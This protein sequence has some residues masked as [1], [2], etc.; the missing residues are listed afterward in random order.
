MFDDWGMFAYT[1]GA[2]KPWGD[3]LTEIDVGIWEER[4]DEDCWQAWVEAK[5]DIAAV[6]LSTAARSAPATARAARA[7][8]TSCRWSW[9]AASRS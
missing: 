2:Y 4:W 6:A 7:R 5:R 1:N 9:A 8:W 3:Y